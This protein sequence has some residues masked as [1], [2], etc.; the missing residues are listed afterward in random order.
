MLAKFQN[1]FRSLG[2]VH[3]PV[4]PELML[5]SVSDQPT[6]SSVRSSPSAY[7]EKNP[8]TEISKKKKSRSLERERINE[9]RYQVPTIDQRY[10]FHFLSPLVTSPRN[11][12]DI[13]LGIQ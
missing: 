5:R 2:I 4:Q 1:D 10:N 12:S 13:S 11:I 9:K 7:N 6:P 8:E 3:E